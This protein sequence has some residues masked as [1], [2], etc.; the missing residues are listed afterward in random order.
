VQF[1]LINLILLAFFKNSVLL[2][3]AQ[4]YSHQLYYYIYEIMGLTYGEQLN[5]CCIAKE[6]TVVYDY[7]MPSFQVNSQC[8][9]LEF[10]KENRSI[11]GHYI[12]YLYSP[13]MT[14]IWEIIIV[15]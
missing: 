10:W 1:I 8:K 14:A 4:E 6:T 2:A 7:K 12:S 13:K 3:C 9:I 11:L 5:K 15:H